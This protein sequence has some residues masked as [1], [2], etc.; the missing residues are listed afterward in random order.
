MP[1]YS[2]GFTIPGILR[3]DGLEACD[4]ELTGREHVVAVALLYLQHLIDLADFKNVLGQS[5][6]DAANEAGHAPQTRRR[7]MSSDAGTRIKD[8]KMSGA[9][10]VGQYLCRF[11]LPPMAHSTSRVGT[12]KCAECGVA[13]EQH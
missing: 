12:S 10:T 11:S 7:G 13:T 1:G 4:S 5:V 6:I 9:G 3:G 8:G 2:S